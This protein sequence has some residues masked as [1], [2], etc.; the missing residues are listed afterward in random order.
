MLKFSTPYDFIFHIHVLLLSFTLFFLFC[1]VLFM[2]IYFFFHLQ[3]SCLILI[4]HSLVL[5]LNV[6]GQSLTFR[7]ISFFFPAW[8][9][10][11]VLFFFKQKSLWILST[12]FCFIMG[13]VRYHWALPTNIIKVQSNFV[14]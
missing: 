8:Q 14:D 3:I 5:L 12:A 7:I 10:S 4:S 13:V 6:T 11:E 2:H 9:N 1:T